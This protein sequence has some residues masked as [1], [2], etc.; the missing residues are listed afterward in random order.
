MPMKKFAIIVFAMVLNLAGTSM[1]ADNTGTG[2]VIT[3]TDSSGSNAVASP[4]YANGYV[5]HTFTNSGTYSNSVAVSADVLV[6][7]GGGGGSA[8]PCSWPDP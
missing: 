8:C 3:Y 4:P 6:V 2:G 5:V 7:G 1:A